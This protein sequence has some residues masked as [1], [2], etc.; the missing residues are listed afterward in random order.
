VHTTI[1]DDELDAD[2][3]LYLTERAIAKRIGVGLKTWRAAAYVLE[4][5]GLPTGDPLFCGR[6]YWPAVKEF[7]DRRNKFGRQL[8]PP[9]LAATTKETADGKDR[10]SR[11][12][13][14]AA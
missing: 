2:D 8:S 1:S 4:K 14:Q 6:R 5:A 3:A 7:L 11:P 13:M 9:R 12:Q 10:Q